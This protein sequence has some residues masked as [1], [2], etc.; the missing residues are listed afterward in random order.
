LEHVLQPL[1]EKELE[2]Y[3]PKINVVNED[4]LEKNLE[5]LD[6]IEKL[7]NEKK[8]ISD[9]LEPKFHFWKF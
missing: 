6:K 7:F 5:K 9:S 3:I 8:I 1:I 4:I 2:K